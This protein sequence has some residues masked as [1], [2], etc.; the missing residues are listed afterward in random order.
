MSFPR[1][2]ESRKKEKHMNVYWV[3]I[4]S[5]KRN[6]TLYTGVTNDL[7]RRVYEHKEKL[8]DGF[9]KKYNA[10][11]LVYAE[12][13]NDVREA[14]FREKCIKKW[15]RAWKLKL[16]EEHNPEWRDLYEDLL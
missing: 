4:F 12:E 14:I 11:Q 16:I 6:G 13:F 1:K 2:R 3:Y 5:S 15:D 7:I 9:T 8:V 10:T